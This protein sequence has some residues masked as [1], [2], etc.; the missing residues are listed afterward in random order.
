[1]KLGKI[2]GTQF[3]LQIFGEEIDLDYNQDRE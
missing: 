3:L 2:Y 1:M